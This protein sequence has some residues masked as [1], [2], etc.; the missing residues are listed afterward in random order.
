MAEYMNKCNYTRKH[1]ITH[2]GHSLWSLT[3]NRDQLIVYW[4]ANL[5]LHFRVT[6]LTDWRLYNIW[7]CGIIKTTLPARA[8][9]FAHFLINLKI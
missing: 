7:L 1:L 8:V 9:S 6:A 2:C 4:I 5:P 3:V